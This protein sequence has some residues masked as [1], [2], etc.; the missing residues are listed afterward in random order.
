MLVSSDVFFYEWD[1]LRG[2]RRVRA[3]RAIDPHPIRRRKKRAR[4]PTRR[5]R[6]S[7]RDRGPRRGLVGTASGNSDRAAASVNRESKPILRRRREL[8]SSWR[9][10]EGVIRGT[11]HFA[12]VVPRFPMGS[13]G[14]DTRRRH[15]SR[16][17]SAFNVVNGVCGECPKRRHR[18]PSARSHASRRARRYRW[19][20][21][22]NPRGRDC[23]P[24]LARKA[25]APPATAAASLARSRA[26]LGSHPRARSLA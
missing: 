11:P 15:H 7:T 21:A 19:H 26:L 2:R 8:T 13:H 1:R 18:E 16:V 24:R 12:T 10:D 6:R 22:W 23:G 3:R 4:P 5:T 17:L 25:A 14:N 9:H 20:A